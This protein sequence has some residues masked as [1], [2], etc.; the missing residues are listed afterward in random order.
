MIEFQKSGAPV[1]FPPSTKKLREN[2]IFA[3]RL[4]QIQTSGATSLLDKTLAE[5]ESHGIKS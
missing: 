1:Q 3:E 2:D 4:G 5:Q